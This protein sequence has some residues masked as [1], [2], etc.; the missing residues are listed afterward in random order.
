MK[1]NFIQSGFN[2][3]HL[4]YRATI[5]IGAFQL[6]NNGLAIEIS[7]FLRAYAFTWPFISLKTTFLRLALRNGLISIAS[8]LLA[9]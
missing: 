1:F 7:P 5:E 8:P 6:A 3:D 4:G 2:F 9:S